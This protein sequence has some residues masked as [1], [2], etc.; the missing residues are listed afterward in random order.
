MRIEA[1]HGG[2]LPVSNSARSGDGFRSS[3]VVARISRAVLACVLMLLVA[4]PTLAASPKADFNA[5]GYADLLWWNVMTGQVAEW[6]MN[7]AVASSEGVIGTVDDTRWR[8][9][10]R[11]D[12]NGDGRTD[13]LWFNRSNGDVAIVLAKAPAPLGGAGV[14]SCSDIGGDFLCGA[15]VSRVGDLGWKVSGVGDFNNDGKA[16]ILWR[17]TGTGDVA[18]WLMNGLTISA[19]TVVQRVPDPAWRISCVG[20]FDGNGK[21]DVLWRNASTG[22]N[23]IWFMNGA[24]VSSAPLINRVADQTWRVA[25]IGDFDKDGKA[26][27]LWRNASTGDVSIWF[28]NAATQKSGPLISRVADTAW[29]IAGVDDYNNDGVADILWRHAGTGQPAM[30]FMNGAGIAGS[31]YTK[32]VP[33]LSWEIFNPCSSDDAAGPNADFDADGKSD[34]VWRNTSTGDNAIWFMDG[35]TQR[36]GPLINPAPD[37]NWRIVGTGD[38]NGDGKADL[39]WR[40]VAT[41]QDAIWFM[42]GSAL[43]NGP[44]INTVADLNWV[45]TGIGDF[46]G[47]GLSDIVWRN[48]ATGQNAIWFMNGQTQTS[49]PLIPTVADQS[50]I[51][52]GTGDFDGDGKA[53]ILWR[54]TATGDVAIWFMNGPSRT[55]APIISR[56]ADPDWK[57]AGV[58][59]FD[60]DGIADI[61][62]RNSSTGQ[63]A[64]WF[65]NGGTVLSGPMIQSATDANWDV[66]LVADLNGDGKADIVW[67]NAATGQT[68]VWLMNGA[69]VLSGPIIATVGSSW[70]VTGTPAAGGAT[71]PI[72]IVPTLNMVCTAKQACSYQVATASGGWSPLHYQLDSLAYGAPPSGMSMNLNGIISGTPSVAGTYTFRVCAVDLGGRFACT[73]VTIQVKAAPDTSPLL[74][75]WTGTYNYAGY[76]SSSGCYFSG[77][78]TLTFNVNTVSGSSISGTV[79]KDGIQIR[80]ALDPYSMCAVRTNNATSSGTFSGT[81]SG[82]SVVINDSGTVYYSPCIDCS[83]FDTFTGTISGTTMSGTLTRNASAYKGTFSVQKQ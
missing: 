55:S 41:G 54:S 78:G 15:V 36:R 32:A 68:A 66:M 69:T 9:V 18:V 70:L 25:G 21:S 51:M 20:D 71:T 33:D 26:D 1:L 64:I 59:D 48:T 30:W 46:N 5:D 50:W 82:S 6:M 27:I 75:T 13:L 16:D 73:S 11:G 79:S 65:M 17:H 29:K 63:N 23:A 67:R 7:G 38:F 14:V 35:T 45:V 56:V 57:I 83:E 12:F 3:G 58:G 72:T 31:S 37:G 42:D 44:L 34:I 62:W 28:M 10:G 52:A 4:L 40:N 49:G 43:T 77:G 74:G 53:D 22:D 81:V 76:N 47:D 80:E 39:L 19:A 61:L 8:I 24:A 2:G 60:G